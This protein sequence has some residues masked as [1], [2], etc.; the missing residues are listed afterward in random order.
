MVSQF[1]QE[2]LLDV[3]HETCQV[4]HYGDQNEVFGVQ[5][6]WLEF[7]LL[8]TSYVTFFS[9][10][11]RFVICKM[12]TITR[13]YRAILITKWNNGIALDK[14]WLFYYAYYFL[15]LFHVIKIKAID[16]SM[17]IIYKISIGKKCLYLWEVIR[18]E[19]FL[20]KLNCTCYSGE[21][22]LFSERK[23]WF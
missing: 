1:L 5:Q 9:S 14:W 22:I 2:H 19:V 12:W 10:D 23:I 8:H 15:S 13:L 17:L 11:I 16:E 18:W 4:T 3:H 20:A 6:T 21:N 7:W